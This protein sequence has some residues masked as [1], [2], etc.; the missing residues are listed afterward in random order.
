M[1]ELMVWGESAPNS[2]YMR[3]DAFAHTPTNSCLL[4]LLGL[5][6]HIVMARSTLRKTRLEARGG[7][8][9]QGSL[10]AWVT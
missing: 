8:S 2:P 9:G 5:S 1:L 6:L 10:Q 7:Q 3:E 4:V